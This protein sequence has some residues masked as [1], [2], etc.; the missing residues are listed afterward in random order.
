MPT[1]LLLVFSPKHD[2]FSSII[3]LLRF[4]SSMS[5][6]RHMSPLP[7]PTSS[8][9][10]IS[11]A[12][13]K[14]LSPNLRSPQFLYPKSRFLPN[15]LSQIPEKL[16][17][18]SAEMLQVLQIGEKNQ[19]RIPNKVLFRRTG[20]GE[21]EDHFLLP[22]LNYHRVEDDGSHRVAT[23]ASNV[24]PFGLSENKERSIREGIYQF[25]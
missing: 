11:V 5:A 9:F 16:V 22:V 10:L 15:F 19:V 1:L 7:S 25:G 2:C 13:C 8:P 4:V 6:C 14:F 20:C 18:K 3:L 24:P 17:A 12:R 21:E 23:L